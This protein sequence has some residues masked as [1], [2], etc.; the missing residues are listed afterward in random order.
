MAHWQEIIAV[1]GC[2]GVWVFVCVR[3]GSVA[4]A[5]GA[6]LYWYED[7]EMRGAEDLAELMESMQGCGTLFF[8]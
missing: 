6:V 2:V 3:V 8:G 1:C 5:E 4:E 7:G